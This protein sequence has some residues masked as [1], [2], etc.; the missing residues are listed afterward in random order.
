MPV[1]QGEPAPPPPPVY[2]AQP[3]AP[4]PMQDPP[5]AYAT[6]PPANQDEPGYGA[7]PNYGTQPGYG[8]EPAYAEPPATR[9]PLPLAPPAA[10]PPGSATASPSATPTGLPADPWQELDAGVMQ[11]LLQRVPLPSPSPALAKLVAGALAAGRPKDD[12]ESAARAG[13]LKAGGRANE[14][15]ELLQVPVESF[16]AEAQG[17]GTAS[18]MALFFLAQDGEEAPELRLAAAERAAALNV[19]DG[20]S[21]ARAYRDTAPK[22]PPSDRTPAALR[23]RLF[24]SLDGQASPATRA[25]S[26]DALLASGKDAGIEAPIAE[27]LAE[28]AAGLAHDPQAAS[29]AE[30][31]IR[32]A[33][34]AGEGQVAW[35]WVET[36]G[37]KVQSWELM[38]GAADPSGARAQAALASGVEIA[39][40]SHLPGP[41]LQRLVTVLD[42]LGEE[43]PIPLWELASQSPTPQD[44]YLPETGVLSALKEASDRGQVGPTIL[45]AATAL[46]PKGP[47]DAHLIALGDTL[48]ALKRVGLEAQ[49][50][51]LALEA[52]VRHWPGGRA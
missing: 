33:A 48:R 11:A 40:R 21:L 15:A 27:A 34:L 52:L 5:P 41:V 24:A 31:G 9:Q 7:E 50:R 43:V 26:I 45:L 8:R 19:I 10:A 37:E 14:L 23:A 36:G 25:E 28:T 47:Q 20:R 51:Q 22:L 35:A 17:E 38:L 46:G 49:A 39:R 6:P 18:P 3:P 4:P 12:R 13:G 32:V 44:G 30:T 2:D 42:A 16:A 1:L 29:F